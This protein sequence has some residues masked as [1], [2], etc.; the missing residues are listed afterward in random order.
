[1]TGWGVWAYDVRS[2]RL[3]MQ[4]CCPHCQAALKLPPDLSASR[5]RCSMCK[6]VFALTRPPE[7]PASPPEEHPVEPLPESPS[8]SASVPFE[9]SDTEEA[10]GWVGG[11]IRVL[12]VLL[13]AAL[14]VAYVYRYELGPSPVGRYRDYV[15]VDVQDMTLLRSNVPGPALCAR[16]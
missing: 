12:C 14:T 13:M 2:R 15:P 11:A 1:L 7:P 4:V 3:A 6:E 9:S 5:V 8:E 16:R 10:R